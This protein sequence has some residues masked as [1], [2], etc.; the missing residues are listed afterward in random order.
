MSPSKWTTEQRHN[1][2]VFVDSPS[3]KNASDSNNENQDP[4]NINNLDRQRD[5]VYE[6]FNGQDDPRNLQKQQDGQRAVRINQD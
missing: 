5:S 3:K 2:R 4:L 6:G 1:Y